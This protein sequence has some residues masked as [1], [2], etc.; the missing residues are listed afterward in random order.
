MVETSDVLLRLASGSPLR[1]NEIFAQAYYALRPVRYRD[2]AK[3]EELVV[4]EKWKTDLL[5]YV[6][7]DG[8]V[9]TADVYI[10]TV[11]FPKAVFGYF[12]GFGAHPADVDEQQAIQ[13]LNDH[14]FSVVAINLHL[15]EKHKD[16]KIGIN[17]NRTEAF[18]YNDD[19]PLHTL[20]PRELP[21]FIGAHSTAGMI[22][23]RVIIERAVQGISLPNSIKH[24]YP[25]CPMYDTAG[26][27]EKFYPVSSRLYLSHALRNADQK[28]GD[29]FFD[30]LHYAIN[31]I[32]HRLQFNNSSAPTHGD[33]LS[34]KAYGA[35]FMHY[36][37][38]LK[39]QGILD[40]LHLPMTFV[41][42]DNDH[43]ACHKTNEYIA[44]TLLGKKIIWGH[45]EHNPHLNPAHFNKLIEH[46]YTTIGHAPPKHEEDHSL[47]DELFGKP[48]EG[49]E[50]PAALGLKEI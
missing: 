11:A 14:G 7:P 44:E 17:F 23:S 22:V 45:S 37:R 42:S 13:A 48:N 30:R 8:S 29:P 1:I 50:H 27:S 3:I 31:G 21:R 4:P 5:Q 26:S 33:V 43:F 19:S 18:I 20:F 32:G 38:Q 15:D 36:V 2:P 39:E 24:V 34:L 25:I 12:T 40:R 6:A 47:L 41:L 16:D 10:S 46:A 35:G 28:T 9:K 49:G